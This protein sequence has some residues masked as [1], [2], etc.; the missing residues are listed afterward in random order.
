MGAV[1]VL[2][3]V[4]GFRGGWVSAPACSVVGL[5]GVGGELLGDGMEVIGPWVGS[6]G[7]GVR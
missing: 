1:T 4:S 3:P 6:W 7:F 2:V 5:G